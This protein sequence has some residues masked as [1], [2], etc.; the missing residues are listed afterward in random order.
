VDKGGSYGDESGGARAGFQALMVAGVPIYF[1]SSCPEG[2]FYLLNTKYLSFHIHTQAYFTF[3]DFH[4]LIPVNQIGYTGV[5]LTLTELVCT[6]PCTQG[7]ING[8]GSLTL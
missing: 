6:K 2:T 1:D 3:S 5:F 4:S 7:Q 8:L